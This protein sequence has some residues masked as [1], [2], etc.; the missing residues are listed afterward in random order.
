MTTIKHYKAEIVFN[1]KDTITYQ[2]DSKVSEKYGVST[3][4]TIRNS[5]RH[6]A[7]M[8]VLFKEKGLIPDLIADL[9]EA[10][11][12]ETIKDIKFT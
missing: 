5:V 10:A 8:L 12:A 6:L 7:T 9:Q 11:K 4:G 2:A 1:A 3:Q